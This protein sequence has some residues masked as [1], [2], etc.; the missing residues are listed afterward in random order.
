MGTLK[1]GTILCSLQGFI[2]KLFDLS[3]VFWVTM[4]A[5][6][7]FVATKYSKKIVVS[8]WMHCV[9]WLTPLIF[10]CGAYSTN[11]FGTIPSGIRDYC[12]IGNRHDSPGWGAVFWVFM[13]FYGWIFLIIIFIIYINVSRRMAIHHIRTQIRMSNDNT[14]VYKQRNEIYYALVILICWPLRAVSRTIDI[15]D[16]SPSDS[17]LMYRDISLLISGLQGFFLSL[18]FFANYQALRRR[19]VQATTTFIWISKSG[20]SKDGSNKH[21]SGKSNARRSLIADRR[22]SIRHNF[23]MAEL[24][25]N[26]N[27]SSHQVSKRIADGTPVNVDDDNGDKVCNNMSSVVPLSVETKVKDG[28]RALSRGGV[29]S[30]LESFRLAWRVQSQSDGEEVPDGAPPAQTVV[31]FVH[32]PGHVNDDPEDEDRELPR[33]AVRTY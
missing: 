32:S 9:C 6:S 30:G 33:D 29:F 12:F 11:R 28:D 10:L 3:S 26:T 16:G 14:R 31:N 5:W 1:D 18:I 7:L 27:Q 8:R 24:S 4:I 22:S 2:T 21:N 15:F 20:R 25:G 19:L 13:S 17:Y 23:N